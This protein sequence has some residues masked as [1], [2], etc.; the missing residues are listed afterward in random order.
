MVREPRALLLE[1]LDELGRNLAHALHVAA[2]AAVQNAAR[3]ALPDLPAVRDHVGTLS[4]HRLGDLEL[5]EQDRRGALLLRELEP[6]L[7]T[8]DRELARNV[9]GELDRLGRAVAHAEQR[10]RRA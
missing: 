10:D 4:Q 9:V 7:P 1:L 2:I 3:D 5:L 8:S 6:F